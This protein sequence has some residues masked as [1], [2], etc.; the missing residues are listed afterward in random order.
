MFALVT[1]EFIQIF[2]GDQW[3]PMA[4]TFQLMLLY[5]LFDPLLVLASK[6]TTAMGEPQALTK[7]RFVQLLFFV[8]AVVGL[9]HFFGIDGIAVA[10]DLMLIT[11]IVIILPRVRHYVDFSLL[12]MLGYPMLGMVLALAIALSVQQ[13]FHTTNP[14]MI[15]LSKG[16]VMTTVY[17]SVLIA[18]ERE[19]LLVAARLVLAFATPS[20]RHS[21]KKTNA[22]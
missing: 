2:L 19:Q 15:L 21:K 4:F 5:T 9:A 3:L 6:L 10:A 13:Q 12:R 22:K 18:F 17:G 7:V 20:S 1:P 14:L 11:G 16:I 8:P